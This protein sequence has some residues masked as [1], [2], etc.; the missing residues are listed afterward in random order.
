MNEVLFFCHIFT[1]ILFILGAFRLG[2]E[3]LMI[4]FAFQVLIANLF[5]PKQMICFG[6]HI[7]CV[8]VYTIGALFSLNM[9]QEFYGKKVAKQSVW[10]T[11]FFLFFFIIMSQFHLKYLPSK[12]DIFQKPFEKILSPSLR[13]VLSSLGA[14]L[15]AQFLDVKLYGLFKR[16]WND[17][18]IMFSFAG[19]ALIS[20]FV[21]TFLFSYLALY[22]MVEALKEIILMSYLIKVGIIFCMTPC[23][24]FLKRIFHGRLQV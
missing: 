22:G 20:Q 16:K 8:D 23:T 10:M 14:M 21:D 1:L 18:K 2:K 17:K 5:I 19:A 4:S 7:T 11:F 24:N 13:I 6:L 3:A 12:A 15:I 9:L